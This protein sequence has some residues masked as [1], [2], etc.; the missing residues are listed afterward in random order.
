MHP[1]KN[2]VSLIKTSKGF[3]LIEVLVSMGLFSLG[4]LSI[5][6]LQLQAHAA[7][8]DSALKNQALSY[9][10][11]RYEIYYLEQYD[12]KDTGILSAKWQKNSQAALP[13]LT[14][15]SQFKNKNT[16]ALTLFWTTNQRNVAC[17][18]S[19]SP[20]RDCLQL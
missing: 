19:H 16:L 10:S 4:L 13:D 8:A 14:V 7:I 20:D 9:A 18:S 2:N 6:T 5:I 15:D 3:S 12:K 1:L 11:S 17:Q